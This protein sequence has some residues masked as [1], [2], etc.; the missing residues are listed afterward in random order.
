M[1]EEDTAIYPAIYLI[2]PEVLQDVQPVPCFLTKS[3]I[4]PFI[5]SIA[6]LC[7]NLDEA[8]FI[9]EDG[10]NSVSDGTAV[11]ISISKP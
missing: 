8:P 4:P 10:G 9:G 2:I 6:N 7:C 1:R 5:T 3:Y 11:A